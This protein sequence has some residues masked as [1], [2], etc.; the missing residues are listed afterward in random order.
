[1]LIGG[2]LVY[3][4]GRT[5][6]PEAKEPPVRLDADPVLPAPPS[7]APTSS[8]QPPS[9]A[10]WTLPIVPPPGV[11]TI[12]RF[13]GST[14][15][16]VQ[17]TKRVDD[18]GC[19]ARVAASI[20]EVLQLSPTPSGRSIFVVMGALD[21][22]AIEACVTSVG[23]KAGWPLRV[24]REGDVTTFIAPQQTHYARFGDGFVVWH[25]QRDSLD[26][27]LSTAK[28]DE[29]AANPF[30]ALAPM[31][32]EAL[33]G[34]M[35]GITT[36]DHSGHLL[37]PKSRGSAFA[38]DMAGSSSVDVLFEDETGAQAAQK[39]LEAKQTDASLPLPV[40]NALGKLKTSISGA[41][42]HIVLPEAVWTEPGL[43]EAVQ[44]LVGTTG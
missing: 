38:I 7:P 24:E 6:S 26:L 33:D 40:R 9:E 18:S 29:A 15:P 39:A 32:P 34:R 20:D 5:P 42:L 11:D 16:M 17:I 19:V 36:L 30:A 10:A 22:T 31:L 28:H 27:S 25:D 4:L 12:G 35:A 37:G 41:Q 1:M 14:W 3:A 8:S 44:S 21:R 23:A 13:E 2:L 43:L